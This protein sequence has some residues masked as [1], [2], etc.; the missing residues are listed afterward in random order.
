VNCTG[1]MA[2]FY[3]CASYATVGCGALAALHGPAKRSTA[4]HCFLLKMVAGSSYDINLAVIAPQ[5][6]HGPAKRSAPHPAPPSL[7]GGKRSQHKMNYS[8][9]RTTYNR[10]EA[11][12]TT[13]GLAVTAIQLM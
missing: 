1:K 12:A 2:S 13:V 3:Y 11:L 4:P 10:Y 5:R 7:G 9:F 8:L 6:L